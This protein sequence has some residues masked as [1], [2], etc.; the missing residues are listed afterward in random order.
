MKKLFTLLT[1]MLCVSVG[2]MADVIGYT[3]AIDGTTLKARELKGMEHVTI[4]APIHGTNIADYEGTSKSVQIDGTAYANTDSWRKSQKNT[5]E[6]Q[7]IGYTLTIESGYKLNISHVDAQIAVADDTYKWYVEILNASGVQVWKSG[8]KTTTKESAGK[9]DADVTDKPD[10]QGLTG[11]ITVN[12]YVQQSGSTKYFS[13]VYLQMT[14]TTEVDERAT[15]TM[16]TNLTPE[17]AG[18]ITPADGTEITEGENA[19]F[20]AQP[21]TGYKFVKWTIDGTDYTTNPYTI[22]NVNSAHT[23][24]ATF[25]ALP[26]VTFSKGDD[27]SIEGVVPDVAYVDGAQ[28]TVPQSYFLVK[29]GYTLTGWNDGSNSYKAGDKINI[30]GD[31]T[32][33][34]EFTANTASLGDAETTVTWPFATSNGAPAM[35]LEGNTGYYAWPATI[36]EATIDVAMLIDTQ[37]DAGISGSRG[38]VDVQENRSQV[39]K[40]TVFVIPAITNMVVKVTATNTGKASTSSMT[41]NGADADTYADG[42]LTY[43]YTG[44]ETSLKIIDQGS[45]LYPSSISVTYPSSSVTYALCSFSEETVD[46]VPGSSVTAPTLSIKDASDNDISS[47]YTVNYSSSNINVA[48]VDESTGAVTLVGNNE[49]TAVITAE[50]TPNS[51]GYQGGKANYTINVTSLFS[52]PYTWDFTTFGTSDTWAMFAK[53][54]TNWTAK[55]ENTYQNKVTVDGYAKANGIT[56]PETRHIKFSNFGGEKFYANKG[57]L[58]L[59]GKKLTITLPKLSAGQYIALDFENPSGSESRGLT[60]GNINETAENKLDKSTRETRIFT[61]K[62]DGEVTLKS[63]SGVRIYSIAVTDEAPTVEVTT[64]NGYATF[65][66]TASVDFSESGAEVYSATVDGTNAVLSKIENG[67]VPANTGVIIKAEGSAIGKIL[68][69]ADALTVSNSLI[70]TAAKSVTTTGIYILVPDDESVKFTTMT[71]GTL[72]AGKAYLLAAASARELNVVFGD[73]TGISELK[74]VKDG[75]EVYNLNGMR[76][77]QPTKGLYIQNGKKIVVK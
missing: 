41:F 24:V 67:I 29:D 51:D 73:A 2:A 37:N 64:T 15:Y 74:G 44:S 20:N 42:V 6:G 4:S 30:S 11:T 3:E 68:N 65:S 7:N 19:V 54:E 38:K 75:T 46:V 48:T 62:E 55:D 25:E 77:A 47:N 60:L 21:S 16:S 10:I 27:T 35:K 5:Y 59:N 22:E 40:G 45:E 70:G 34:A 26:K 72:K 53:D 76:V 63:T 12:L 43:T 31:V 23:A 33:T 58:Q 66:H 18:T 57:S 1:L 71:S 39:N 50:I 61:V 9:L 17:G 49:G 69:K 28:F 13:I 14:A 8:E 32:L 52:T 56:I 36:G